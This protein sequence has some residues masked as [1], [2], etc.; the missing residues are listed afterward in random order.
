M[1][2]SGIRLCSQG[3]EVDLVVA[4]HFE[5]LQALPAREEVVGD[6][7]DVVALEARQA[8]LQEVEA[9]VD[10]VDEPDLMSQEGNGPDAAR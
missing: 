9:L 10:V 8:P 5:V 6:V 4:A 7:Q 2:G 1:V 3:V